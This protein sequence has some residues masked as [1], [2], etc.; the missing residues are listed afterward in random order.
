MALSTIKPASIDLSATFAFTGTVTGTNGKLV[1][2]SRAFL[3]SGTVTL[4]TSST[5]DTGFDHI[6]QFE[7]FGE[8]KIDLLKD[9][10]KE[11]RYVRIDFYI[12]S[13]EWKDKF[14]NTLNIKD[15]I[16]EDDIIVNDDIPFA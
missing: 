8:T 7:I 5:T 1:N 16:L 9:K 13:N 10:I 12:K 2:T 14:F 11:E 15:V 3:T 6:H 4:N